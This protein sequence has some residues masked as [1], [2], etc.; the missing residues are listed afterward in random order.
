MQLGRSLNIVTLYE[1]YEDDQHVH[2]QLELCA[3]PSPCRH[4]NLDGLPA[5]GLKLEHLPRHLRMAVVGWWGGVVG[6]RGRMA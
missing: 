6:W 3:R 4:L 1:V 5:R 2:L